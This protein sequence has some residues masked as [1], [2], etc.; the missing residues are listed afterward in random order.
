[1]SVR[2]TAHAIGTPNTTHSEAAASPTT[3]E[4]SS[5]SM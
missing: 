3:R 1:M 5:A 4:L 2:E